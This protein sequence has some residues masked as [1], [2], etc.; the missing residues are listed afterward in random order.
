MNTQVEMKINLA[1]MFSGI[2]SV[3]QTFIKLKIK[4]NIILACD[5][6]NIELDINYEKERE[7]IA[8][9]KTIKEKNIYV[10]ELYSKNSRKTNFVEKTY[11]QNYKIRKEDFF[12][13]IKLIKGSDYENKVDLLVG[14][15]PCQSFS[16]IGK[17]AGFE[18]TRGTLFYE[19]ARMIKEILPKVFI[20]ENVFGMLKHDNGKTW[21]VVQSV[22]DELGYHYKYQV[23]DAKDYGIPQGRRRVFVVGFKNIENYNKFEFPKP[24]KLNITMQDL[25][26]DNIKEGCVYFKN[27]K[28]FIDNNQGGQEVE[29][30]YY[31]SKKLFKYVMN[32]G[33]KNFIHIPKIDLP[34]ARALLSTMGNTHRASVNNYVT[35]NGRIRALHPRE[36]LRLM[37]YPDDFKIV[38]SKAQIYKQVGNSIVVNVMSA[39]VE[40]IMKSLEK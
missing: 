30:K 3:E 25:L 11:L 32:P 19:Y 7:V 16:V 37:G 14:G 34:I 6:G 1:T 2:G 21:D 22:F 29:E 33:T 27:K 13:D 40:K 10:R 38:V 9:L 26:L 17:K 31:L 18:D 5:N 20:Y 23:L 39:I 12:Y 36:T 8:K 24:I 35:T 28:L 15:S 4:H